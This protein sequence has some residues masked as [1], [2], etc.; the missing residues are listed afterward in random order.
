MYLAEASCDTDAITGFMQQSFPSTY[1]KVSS[2]LSAVLI[3]SILCTEL[4]KY[5][6]DYNDLS[7]IKD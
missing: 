7:Q 4:G 2:E 3:H 1:L 6:V 5:Y